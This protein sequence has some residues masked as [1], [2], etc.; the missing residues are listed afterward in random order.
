MEPEER[1]IPSLLTLCRQIARN[2]NDLEASWKVVEQNPFCADLKSSQGI[3]ISIYCDGLYHSKPSLQGKRLEIH[4][5]YQH[6]C[7]GHPY[8]TVGQLPRIGVSADRPAQQIASDIRRRLIPDVIH[9]TNL[10]KEWAART[11]RDHRA[12]EATLK[13]LIKAGEGS[14]YAFNPGESYR[15]GQVWRHDPHWTAAVDYH[16]KVTLELRDVSPALAVKIVKLI[17][18]EA[19]KRT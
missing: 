17:K 14:R 9:H 2:L 15:A 1:T 12:K 11:L 4:G 5:V 16:C 10:A 7:F 3:A 18:A 8:Y 6:D 13:R 19:E